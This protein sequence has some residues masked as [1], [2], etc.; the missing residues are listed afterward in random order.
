M[1]DSINGKKGEKLGE[2]SVGEKEL[3]YLYED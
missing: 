3:R 1:P 2:W